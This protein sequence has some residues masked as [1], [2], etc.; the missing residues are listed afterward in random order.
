[1]NE[2]F[3]WDYLAS[4]PARFAPIV[5]EM[6]RRVVAPLSPERGSE[7]V[8]LARKP[9]AHRRMV[10]DRVIEAVAQARGFRIVYPEDLD[11]LEQAHLLYDAQFVAGPEGSAF[12]LGFF[13][14]PGTRICI[15]DHPH[16]AGLP[17]L[18]GP[19]GAIGVE[20][21]VFT[22]PYSRI[23]DEWPHMSDYEI[24]EVAFCRFLDRWLR[25]NTP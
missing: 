15:L 20:T 16:T 10:N 7:R 9:S 22:G 25:D 23:H 1:M 18:T 11:F 6:A 24:D 17:L 4:P 2:R 13:S 5:R 21:V 12:F 14:Q 8:F 19:L 3:R